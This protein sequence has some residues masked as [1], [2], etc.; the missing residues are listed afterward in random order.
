MTRRRR[1]KPKTSQE[2][3]PAEGASP[4]PEAL[5]PEAPSPFLEVPP[6]PAPAPAEVQTESVSA[7]PLPA[8]ALPA[9]PGAELL[10]EEAGSG[11]VS[12]GPTGQVTPGQPS[13]GHGRHRRRR[14]RRGRGRGKGPQPGAPV[15]PA[16]GGQ[17][18]AA[19]EGEPAPP[20][21]RHEESDEG[22]AEEMEIEAEAEEIPPAKATKE[23]LIN[24]AEGE[25][26]RIAIVDR[27]ILEELYLER[28]GV[29]RHVG[30]IYKGR[31]TNV[32]PSI[33][34]AFVDIGMLK[35]GFLHASDVIPAAWP[36]RKHHPEAEG[37]GDGRNEHRP[38]IQTILRPGDEVI[39][40]ITKEGIGTKGPSLTTSLS[41]PGRYLVLMPSLP[42]LGVSRK[43][44]DGTRREL[45]DAL[46][47]LNPPK[48]MGFIIRTAGQ[49]KSKRELQRDLQYLVRL[50]KAVQA[51]AQSS[52]AP[53]EVFRESDLV[54]R[55]LRD[56]FTPAIRT[57]WVDSES[58]LKRVHEFMQIAMPRQVEAAKLYAEAVPLF[59][60]YKLEEAIEQIYSRIVALPR[61]GT[62]V[63]DQTEALV[64]IDVNSAK[65][66]H[67]KDAEESAHQLNVIAA[68]E[69]ARQ[70]RLRD[71]GGL[72]LMDFVDME[73]AENRR[74]VEKALRDAFKGDR[75]RS[76]M[77]RMS[78]FGIVEMTRQRVQPSLER[79]TYMDCPHCRGTG[80]I[81]TRDSMALEV[82]RHL[83][84]LMSRQQ[85]ATVEVTLHP[86]VADSVNNLKREALAHMESEF[87]KRIRILV[88]PGVGVE[89]VNY[90]CLDDRAS[91]V[92]EERGTPAAG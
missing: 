92:R 14:G 2:T 68:K 62:L 73:K 32:E 74:H 72:I 80:I 56:I 71:L 50:W 57:I 3:A 11:A 10:P 87:H 26:C 22:E 27:G 69:I 75:A 48:D 45:R 34:A 51:R 31:I 79:A 83:R 24:V 88:D 39:V 66:R 53:A 36:R 6:A 9:A 37:G 91:E 33:Q 17:P 18:A 84:L 54:V 8:A 1:S 85:V 46:E 81:K 43:I 60:K 70:V 42:R 90:R 77:L 78:K 29:Q 13:P 41:I 40:Q 52:K 55:T 89:Y 49:G 76:R 61:G 19:D 20:A 7:L 59:H 65:F 25:E 12:E 5:P 28:A 15:A 44:E 64:A 38:P 35:N 86:E 30:N 58:V 4:T 67:G 47:S 63:I 21:P 82:M 16:E 23:M